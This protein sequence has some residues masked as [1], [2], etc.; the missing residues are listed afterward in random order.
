[1]PPEHFSWPFIEIYADNFRNISVLGQR[2]GNVIL[3]VQR[4][5]KVVVLCYV[6]IWSAPSWI[7]AFYTPS[8]PFVGQIRLCDIVTNILSISEVFIHIVIPL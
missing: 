4:K 8:S 2:V 3:L 7:T 5:T 6:W 1:M